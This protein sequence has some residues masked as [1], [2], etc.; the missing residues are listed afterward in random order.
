M[1]RARAE[2]GR[3]M[4]ERLPVL[5]QKAVPVAAYDAVSMPNVMRSR[6]GARSPARMNGIGHDEHMRFPG[7]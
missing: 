4:M 2:R 7:G 5:S 1:G 3:T 6:N